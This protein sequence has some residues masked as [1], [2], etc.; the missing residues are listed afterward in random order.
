M[1]AAL[2]Q[3]NFLCKYI[4]IWT[5]LPRNLLP[6]N[7][8]KSVCYGLQL[9]LIAGNFK[10][11]GTLLLSKQKQLFLEIES[12]MVSFTLYPTLLFLPA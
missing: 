8:K 7:G 10:P 6:C 9:V 12:D 5:Q 3:P 4:F 2:Y 1:I 11:K